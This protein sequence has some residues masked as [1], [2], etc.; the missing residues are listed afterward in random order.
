MADEKLILDAKRFGTSLREFKSA[1]RK[2][3]PQISRQVTSRTLR[4][5]ISALAEKWFAE[6]SKRPGIIACTSPKYFGDVN[7]HFQRLLLFA[8]RAAVRRRYD[9][10]LAAIL[11]GYTADL[12]VPLMQGGDAGQAE[13]VAVAGESNAISTASSGRTDAEGFLPTAFVGH[14][15][16]SAD[17]PIANCITEG[18]KAMGITVVTGKRPKADRISEKVKKLIEAQHLFVGIFTRRDKLVGKTTWST[19][20]WVIEEKAYAFA[21]N[22]KL[23]L[24]KEVDVD[25]IGG[26]TGDYE[27]IEFE[28]DAL[29]E[30]ILA[31]FQLFSLSVK[32]LQ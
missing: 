12:L 24:L 28:R 10:E 19:S 2:A 31:L 5:E 11:R 23:I 14:S 13:A 7:V 21:K 22:K 26:I 32:G 17:T 6:L 1:L 18:L 30:A 3:Y 16:A 15:F 20:T 4:T 27:F 8:D 25:S 29:Q 9:E